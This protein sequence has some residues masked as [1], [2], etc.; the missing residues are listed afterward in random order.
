MSGMRIAGR[1]GMFERSHSEATR[2]KTV[3]WS[4]IDPRCTGCFKICQ[5]KLLAVRA[6]I[7]VV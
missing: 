5:Q 7:Y 1:C 4:C 2:L 3:R 6:P